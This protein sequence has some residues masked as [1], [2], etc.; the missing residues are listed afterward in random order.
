MA[1]AVAASIVADIACKSDVVI[2]AKEGE[3]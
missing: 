2:A 1:V 3:L